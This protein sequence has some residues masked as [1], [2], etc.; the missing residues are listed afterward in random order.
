MLYS[1]SLRS[2]QLLRQRSRPLLRRA[3]GPLENRQDLLYHA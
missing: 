3:T 1:L 2:R